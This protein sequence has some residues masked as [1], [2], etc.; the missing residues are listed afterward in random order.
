MIN[1]GTSA[2]KTKNL[3]VVDE[4]S[5]LLNVSQLATYCALLHACTNTDLE[6]LF[7]EL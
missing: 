3:T 6:P 1:D 7:T 2:G 4:S 5:G